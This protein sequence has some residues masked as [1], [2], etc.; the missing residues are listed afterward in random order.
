MLLSTAGGGTIARHRP[1]PGSHQPDRQRNRGEED[2]ADPLQ[3]RDLVLD[4]R[5]AAEEIVC[6]GQTVVDELACLEGEGVQGVIKADT[7]RIM[8]NDWNVGQFR[9]A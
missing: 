7:C 6:H 4:E 1:S 2:I 8:Q 3:A 9:T 5:A